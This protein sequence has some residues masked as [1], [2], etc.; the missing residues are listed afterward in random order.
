ML[1]DVEQIT[2][3]DMEH[4][5]LESDLLPGLKQRILGVIPIEI[6]HWPQ[7]ITTCAF[8]AHRLPADFLRATANGEG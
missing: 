7:I 6:L 1:E 2:P 8:E 3:L 5:V 4:H